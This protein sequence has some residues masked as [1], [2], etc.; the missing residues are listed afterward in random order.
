MATFELIVPTIIE[1]QLTGKFGAVRKEHRGR[2]FEVQF[3]N[4]GQTVCWKD[5]KAIAWEKL[6]HAIRKAAHDGFAVIKQGHDMR[7]QAQQRD[8]DSAGD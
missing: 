8:R 3:W 2:R 5:G 7:R 4:H 6:P 1:T